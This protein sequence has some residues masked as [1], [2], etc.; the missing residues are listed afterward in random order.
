VHFSCEA[1]GHVQAEISADIVL[2]LAPDLAC[3]VAGGGGGVHCA[4][5]G[6]PGLS[7]VM[8]FTARWA[9]LG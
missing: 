6:V 9:S 4:K 3:W 1:R 8:H 5:R 2:A 7:S